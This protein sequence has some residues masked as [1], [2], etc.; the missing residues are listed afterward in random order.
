MYPQ[1]PEEE[2]KSKAIF[3]LT[4]N[5]GPVIHAQRAYLLAL[6]RVQAL[7]SSSDGGA[8]IWQRDLPLLLPAGP[9]LPQTLQWLEC[10]HLAV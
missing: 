2:R 6:A 10:L 9:N 1:K 8:G 5:S 7:A 4:R 3:P